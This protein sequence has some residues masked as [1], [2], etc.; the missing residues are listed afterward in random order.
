MIDAVR[1][2][3]DFFQ[4][5][6][7]DMQM[8]LSSLA[9]HLDQL[10]LAYYSTTDVEGDHENLDTPPHD[11]SAVYGRMG[12]L[13]PSLGYYADVEPT[14]DFDQKPS[15]GDAIDD[16]ADIYSDMVDV[17]WYAENASLNEATWHFRFGYQVHW[18]A[19]LHN[20]RRYLATS[21]VAAW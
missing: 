11:Y 9:Q 2:Y 12:A 21:D 8:R 5:P 15:I 7:K 16:L 19:H 6:P 20:V 4:S 10:V 18:G 13:F 1:Q 14:E 3:L 17:V